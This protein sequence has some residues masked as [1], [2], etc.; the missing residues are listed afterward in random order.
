MARRHI[1]DCAARMDEMRPAHD[2][3]GR[4]NGNVGWAVEA[5][6]RASIERPD[7]FDGAGSSY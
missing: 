2:P 7:L 3:R 1:Q 5:R 4:G 6:H